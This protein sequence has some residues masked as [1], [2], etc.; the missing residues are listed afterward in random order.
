M[1][2]FFLLLFKYSSFYFYS[3]QTQACREKFQVSYLGRKTDP[4]T[5]VPDPPSYPLTTGLKQFL[6]VPVP[7]RWFISQNDSDIYFFTSNRWR[8]KRRSPV[9][10]FRRQKYTKRLIQLRILSKTSVIA[11][12]PFQISSY[13]CIK[14]FDQKSRK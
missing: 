14:I 4:I 5:D 6:S 2:S 1:V 12:K 9:S 3:N 10:Y 7:G 11:S 13:S 8:R